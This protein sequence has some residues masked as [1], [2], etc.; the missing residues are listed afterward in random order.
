MKHGNT[1]PP[2]VVVSALEAF[3]TSLTMVLGNLL[4]LSQL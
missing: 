2:E 1:L 4:E 3:K